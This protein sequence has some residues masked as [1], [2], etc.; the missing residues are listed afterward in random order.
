[1]KINF[2][3]TKKKIITKLILI[4]KMVDMICRNLQHV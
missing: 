3:L 2:S 1:M 4:V